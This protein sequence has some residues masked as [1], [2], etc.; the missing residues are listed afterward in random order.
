M[1]NFLKILGVKK[2]CLARPSKENLS[3]VHDFGNFWCDLGWFGDVLEWFWNAES[4]SIIKRFVKFINVWTDQLCLNG[5]KTLGRKC[6]AFFTSLILS[7][8]SWHCVQ[9]FEIGSKT[10]HY[11]TQVDFKSSSFGL[12]AMFVSGPSELAW[13]D[14]FIR[15]SSKRIY[16]KAIN[17][18]RNTCSIPAVT[19]FKRQ[20]LCN[21]CN[22]PRPYGKSPLHIYFGV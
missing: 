22:I 15:R 3:Q 19:I 20:K 21:Q 1:R 16:V 7:W 6:F 5:C 11:E 13:W 8:W 18:S 9:N 17:F 2:N 12:A 10:Q 14:Y 4:Q